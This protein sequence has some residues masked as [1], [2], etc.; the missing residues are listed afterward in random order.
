MVID[1]A[2]TTAPFGGQTLVEI[3]RLPGSP[4]LIVRGQVAAG[5]KPVAIN[6]SVD[7]P[8]RVYLGAVREAFRR[9]GIFVA[10]GV[11]DADDLGSPRPDGLVNLI[12]DSSPPLGDII[13]VALKWSRNIYAE[14]LLM[15]LAPPGEPATSGRGLERL[16]E[17]LQGWGI[18]PDHYLSR[19]GSGLSRY[20]YLTADALTTLLTTLTADPRHAA[21][22][23]STLPVAGLSGTLANRMRGTPAENRVHAKTGTM[24][25]V[26]S[27]SGYVTTLSGETIVFA[28]IANHFRV[29]P[30]EIDAITD[31]ALNRI[32]Q[33]A[34]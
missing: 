33:F 9:N 24:S 16:R 23:H 14:T 4:T 20:D 34:R 29:S 3:A 5:A 18:L 15:A 13:D 2:V 10:G 30:A 1:H 19:D 22:F 28:I 21:A 12:V 27:L 11:A 32:V 26:R 6:A 31:N 17:T 7:N 8:T 25:N